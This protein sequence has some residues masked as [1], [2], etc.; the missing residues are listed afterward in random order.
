MSSSVQRKNH[1]I[2]PCDSNRK[3][4]LLTHLITLFK[5]K[6]ILIVSSESIPDLH[7][8]Q[9]VTVILDADVTVSE[10]N[11]YDVLISYDLPE[12]A[13][14]YMSRFAHAKEM[15]L[16]L[17][18][19][20][21]QKYL[22][23]IETLLGRTIIQETIPGFE[24]SFG[25]AVENQ[26]KEERKAR[27]AEREAQEATSSTPRRHDRGEKRPFKSKDDGFSSKKQHHSKPRFIGKDKNGKP[28]FEGKTRERNHYIDGTPRTAEEKATQSK[29]KSKPKFFGSD[30]D[31]K[32]GSDKQKREY[33]DKKGGSNDKKSFDKTKKPFGDKPKNKDGGKSYGNKKP[34][35]KKPNDSR[36]PEAKQPAASSRPPRRINVKSLKPKEEKE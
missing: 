6:K 36:K 1:K 33:G 24:P 26:Q 34:Y 25:I 19:A 32:N 18:S 12:K 35:E 14:I 31:K 2:H 8:T 23:P 10:K 29:Y 9:N 22:Y 3:S 28:M 11:D 16:I 21:D 7:S 27:R 20:E 4:E 17:L 30:A 13:I 5:E 15:A